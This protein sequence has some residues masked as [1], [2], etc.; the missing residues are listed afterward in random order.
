VQKFKELLTNLILFAD[1]SQRIEELNRNLIIAK[2]KLN[3]EIL[4]ES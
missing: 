3:E 1:P 4:M 2:Q